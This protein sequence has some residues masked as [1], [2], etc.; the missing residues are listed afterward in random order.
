MCWA[1]RHCCLQCSACQPTLL[2]SLQQE[3]HLLV[4][5]S[6][7]LPAAQTQLAAIV[8]TSYYQP[9]H[10]HGHGDNQRCCL[11]H[12]LQVGSLDIKIQAPCN[13][14][15][16][17]DPTGP[18]LVGD[19]LPEDANKMYVYPIVA[20]I[21]LMILALGATICGALL[22]KY[23]PYLHT[24]KHTGHKP[25]AKPAGEG[26]LLHK[27]VALPAK[28]SFF[29]VCSAQP[30]LL[31]CQWLRHMCNRNLVQICLSCGHWVAPGCHSLVWLTA[32]VLHTLSCAH[33]SADSYPI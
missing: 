7:S 1:R 32:L 26:Q 16:C 25:H 19:T 15:E 3:L 5:L 6:Q 8:T 33:T 12:F 10:Q 14:S 23:L 13:A 29:P 2:Q 4:H 28:G 30:V 22:C 21:P 9:Q 27:Y 17:L 31:A 20:A 11:H 24:Q 18:V